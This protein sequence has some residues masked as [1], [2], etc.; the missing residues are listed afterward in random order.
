MCI[1]MEGRTW[2]LSATLKTSMTQYVMCKKVTERSKK[3]SHS[4]VEYQNQNTV[5]YKSTIF[6]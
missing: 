2:L 4:C 3:I 5:N 6:W 1:F